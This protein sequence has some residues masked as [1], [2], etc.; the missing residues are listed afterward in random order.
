MNFDI[1]AGFILDYIASEKAIMM[2]GLLRSIYLK[3]QEDK[4]VIGYG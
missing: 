4:N 2:E 1:I 3:Q